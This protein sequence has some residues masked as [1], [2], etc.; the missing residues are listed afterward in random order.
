MET[1]HQSHEGA[2]TAEAEVE[3]GTG[4]LSN[5]ALGQRGDSTK[6]EVAPGTG[7]PSNEALGQ[8]GDSTEQEIAPGTGPLSNEALDHQEASGGPASGGGMPT[9]AESPSGEQQPFAPAADEL[10]SVSEQY[11]PASDE[12]DVERAPSEGEPE[13]GVEGPYGPASDELAVETQD[14]QEQVDYEQVE[15]QG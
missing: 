6:P 3:P 4:P 2:D 12:L 8:R 9:H 13:P 10:R 7:P 5:E 15:Y 11:A 14:A 1:F